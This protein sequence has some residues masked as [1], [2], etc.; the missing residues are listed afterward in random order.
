[1]APLKILQHFVQLLGGRLGIEPEDAVDDMVR[2]RL[3]RRIEIARL[4]RW[5]EGTHDH[6]RR[7]RPQIK[8]LSVQEGKL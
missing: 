2:A 6:P 5:L 3:V 4:G 7:I 8:S 1:M